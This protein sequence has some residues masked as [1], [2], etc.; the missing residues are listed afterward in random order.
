[1]YGLHQAIIWLIRLNLSI[2]RFELDAKF[3]VDSFHSS[4]LDELEFGRAIQECQVL[5]H[6]GVSFFI[7]FTKRHCNNAAHVL[8]RVLCSCISFL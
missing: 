3:V 8:A 6:Q 1:M 7:C 2:V 5:C 4:R